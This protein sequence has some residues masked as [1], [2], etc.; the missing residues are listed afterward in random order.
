MKKI[1]L[2]TFVIC[3]GCAKTG[4]IDT[5]DGKTF[6]INHGG[7]ITYIEH[8]NKD[9]LKEGDVVKY[10]SKKLKKLK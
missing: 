3:T 10:T 6:K 8:D 4:V 1:L 5:I 2:F 9:N 7:N